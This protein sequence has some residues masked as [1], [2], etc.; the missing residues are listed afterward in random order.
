MWWTCSSMNSSLQSLALFRE[1]NTTVK[2]FGP[3]VHEGL[4]GVLVG[5][6]S[7]RQAVQTQQTL[8]NVA[9]SAA[10]G[11]AVI[12]SS[13]NQFSKHTV[14]LLVRAGLQHLGY[15]Q[16]L[17]ASSLCDSFS[18]INTKTITLLKIHG[19]SQWFCPEQ[20]FCLLHIGTLSGELGVT[21]HLKLH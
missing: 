5:L 20:H 11:K 1:Q 17:F 9:V 19:S 16:W 18:L 10:M 13:L 3:P 14:L 6:C 2:M 8:E 12:W 15:W 7:A 4:R 21:P